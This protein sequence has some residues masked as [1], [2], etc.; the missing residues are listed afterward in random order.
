MSG[1]YSVSL[2][3]R[4]RLVVP[5]ELRDRRGWREGT[6]LV[7][8]E[9]PRGVVLLPRQELRDLVR[10]DLSGSDVVAELLAERRAAA[11][12]EDR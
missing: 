7:L 2:G 8:V 6:A 3:D 11:E 5:A 4:G 9:T 12:A 10:S 1:T